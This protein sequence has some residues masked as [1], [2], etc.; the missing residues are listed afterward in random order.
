[1]RRLTEKDPSTGEL[2]ISE[3]PDISDLPD[4]VTEAFVNGRFFMTEEDGPKALWIALP[5]E[6]G[7][8]GVAFRAAPT[9]LLLYDDDEGYIRVLAEVEFFLS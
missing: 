2:A 1:M 8:V 6:Y 4:W 9:S 3:S 5:I 7:D